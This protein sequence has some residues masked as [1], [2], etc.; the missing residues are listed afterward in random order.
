MTDEAGSQDPAGTPA[1]P[2]EV[3]PAAPMPSAP[4]PAATAPGTGEV[5]MMPA[6]VGTST[7]EPSAPPAPEPAPAAAPTPAPVSSRRS[8]V[9]IVGWVLAGVG[10]LLAA[11]FVVMWIVTSGDLKDTRGELSASEATVE[12]LNGSLADLTGAK[13]E[14]DVRVD[15]LQ[16]QLDTC[17]DAARISQTFETIFENTYGNA[18]SIG[19]FFNGLKK[20]NGMTRK[21]SIAL[22]DCLSDIK[23]VSALRG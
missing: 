15:E 2:A 23:E 21:V 17:A 22:H 19:G 18:K 9:G 20:A 12:Q 10:I 1:P 14:V 8:R 13:E 16:A 11:V 7:S 5:P 3:A 4:A 6:P